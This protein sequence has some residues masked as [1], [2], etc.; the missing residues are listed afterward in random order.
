MALIAAALLAVDQ[1]VRWA[2]RATVAPGEDWV[3]LSSHLA[4]AHHRNDGIAF[5]LFAGSGRAVGLLTAVALPLAAVGLA[6]F[7]RERLAAAI[8]GG[9][10]L[11]G[12]ISNLLDR[13]LRGEVTDYI[14]VGIWP[15]FNLADA[16]IVCGVALF[17]W[18]LGHDH[19]RLDPGTDQP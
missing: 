9:L 2:I 18:V 16:A 14:E 17:V 5:G 13:L 7:A 4:I 19:Q 1:I 11:G 15:A 8:C 12:A 3:S 6:L 10:L